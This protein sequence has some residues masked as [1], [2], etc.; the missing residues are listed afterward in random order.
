MRVMACVEDN[1]VRGI[2]SIPLDLRVISVA[3][4]IRPIALLFRWS[5]RRWGSSR[6]RPS[7]VPCPE[8]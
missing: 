1:E 6:W 7:E 5:S 8:L 2:P 4:M 3:A